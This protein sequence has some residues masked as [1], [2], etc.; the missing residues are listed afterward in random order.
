MENGKDIN[1]LL[2]LPL[3]FVIDILEERNKPQY[4]DSFFDLL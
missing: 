1:E 3:R 2:K 4:S